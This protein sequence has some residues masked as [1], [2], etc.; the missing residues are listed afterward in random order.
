LSAITLHGLKQPEH[1]SVVFGI[2]TQQ[3]T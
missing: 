2:P 1:N 3:S